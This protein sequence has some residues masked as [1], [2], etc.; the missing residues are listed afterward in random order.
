[1]DW[2]KS[3]SSGTSM[4]KAIANANKTLLKEQKLIDKIESAEQTSRVNVESIP[5]SATNTILEG[6]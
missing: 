6:G 5:T 2:N 4:N 1:M 3:N